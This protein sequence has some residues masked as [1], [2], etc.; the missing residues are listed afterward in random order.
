MKCYLLFKENGYTSK[1]DSPDLKIICLLYATGCYTL[2]K[3]LCPQ[4]VLNIVDN[5]EEIPAQTKHLSVFRSY[6]PLINGDRIQS[7]FSLHTVYKLLLL[8]ARKLRFK[9]TDTS[10]P[11]KNGY[12]L[13]VQQRHALQ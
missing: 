1:N 12:V 5:Y 13:S 4:N 7:T 10:L 9:G 8:H 3:G 2:M 11:S 6:S